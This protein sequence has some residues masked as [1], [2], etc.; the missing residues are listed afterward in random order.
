MNHKHM[1]NNL[2][3]RLFTLYNNKCWDFWHTFNLK[4]DHLTRPDKTIL[5]NV[6]KQPNNTLQNILNDTSSPPHDAVGAAE[7]PAVGANRSKSTRSL[8][9]LL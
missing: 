5:K 7:A 3:L 6:I 8:K 4:C 1:N 2:N 9:P